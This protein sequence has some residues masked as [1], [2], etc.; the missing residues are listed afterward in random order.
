MT[1]G[2]SNYFSVLLNALE[3]VTRGYEQGVSTYEPLSICRRAAVPRSPV[4]SPRMSKG[5]VFKITSLIAYRMHMITKYFEAKG[6][7]LLMVAGNPPPSIIIL[8]VSLLLGNLENFGMFWIFGIFL[9]FL[10]F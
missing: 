4:C 9:D 10:D 1:G 2:V 7:A 5:A 6:F 3:A 8:A